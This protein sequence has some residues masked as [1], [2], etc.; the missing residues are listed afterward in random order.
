MPFYYIVRVWLVSESHELEQ[1]HMFECD[2][3]TAVRPIDCTVVH[4]GGC[5]KQYAIMEEGVWNPQ[6]CALAPRTTKLLRELPFLC[7][8]LFGM[9]KSIVQ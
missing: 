3:L 8:S 7:E 4:Q 6:L 1:R 5:W 2:F 9:F